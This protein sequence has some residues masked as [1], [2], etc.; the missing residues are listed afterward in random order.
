MVV[1]GG[2][3]EAMV[4]TDHFKNDSNIE[5]S[6]AKSN[7][8]TCPLKVFSDSYANKPVTLVLKINKASFLLTVKN[9]FAPH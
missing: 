6:F 5:T 2:K 7:P 1:F 4:Y 3:N 8:P 9:I